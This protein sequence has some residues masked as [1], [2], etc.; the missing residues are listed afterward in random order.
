MPAGF[1]AST[2]ISRATGLHPPD[3]ASVACHFPAA[4]FATSANQKYGSPPWR[5][6][7][8]AATLPSGATSDSAPS[9]GFSATTITRSGAPVHGP[10]GDGSTVRSAASA[11]LRPRSAGD[12][13]AETS[14]AERAA[15]NQRARSI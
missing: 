14:K 6:G 13:V 11:Q 1:R 10:A 2:V 9:T 15:A 3:A 7:A 12:P 8:V 5:S 4:G